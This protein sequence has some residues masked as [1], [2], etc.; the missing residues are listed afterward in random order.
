[1]EQ[2]RKNVYVLWLAVFV[3]AICWTMVMPFMPD[4]L[5]ELGVK[6]A[7]EFWSGIIISASAVCNMVMAPVW[8]AVGD[9]YGRRPMMLRAGF[10]LA[11]GYVLMAVA[12]GPVSLLLVRMMIGLF[13]G[14]VPMAMAMVGVSTPR[15][16]V[17]RALG[18][19]QAAWFAGGMIG[20]VVGGVL[21]DWV[22]IR[23]SSWAAGVIVT[24]AT[25]LVLVTV[26]EEFTPEPSEKGNFI[27]DLKV[28]ASHK[29]LMVIVMITMA[30]QASLMALEPV[31]V[32]FVKSIEGPGSPS[33][34]AGLLFSIPGLAFV[35]MAPWWARK[36]EKIGYARTVGLGLL[37]SAVLFIFQAFATSA[38]QLGGLRL[39]LG[40]AGASVGPGVAALL[41]TTLP[42]GLRGRGFG[43]NQAASSAGA[44]VGPLLGGYIGS[45]IN[46]RFVFIL[47]ALI[48]F[49]GY[50]WAV[51]VVEPRVLA[52]GEQAVS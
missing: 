32:P 38:W 18:F 39:V 8:G 19:V 47:T 27:A 14:F 23:G 31:L 16:E 25:A 40:M 44:I 13:T 33:W 3:A 17:G 37:G 28:A 46:V 29:L 35:V 24:F 12:Q 20:P 30:T 2:W 41:S 51:R 48:S 22:G 15:H 7:P 21:A 36:G 6:K 1:L 4:Y 49:A 43:L 26:K 9:R 11:V 10:F 5:V 50:L 34:L 45:F 52:N 42:K